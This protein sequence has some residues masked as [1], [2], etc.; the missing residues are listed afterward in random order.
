VSLVEIVHTS[1]F[2]IVVYQHVL[3]QSRFLWMIVLESSQ[4]FNESGLNLS[5]AMSNI[6]E[7]TSLSFTGN[8][9]DARTLDFVDSNFA[10]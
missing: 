9:V 4:M 10:F 8:L 2:S 1:S 6:F 7:N 3:R 5:P